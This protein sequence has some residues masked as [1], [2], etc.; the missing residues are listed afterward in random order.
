[1]NHHREKE[2]P[3]AHVIAVQLLGPSLQS[4]SKQVAHLERL[5]TVNGR[6]LMATL[7]DDTASATAMV[8]I[9]GRRYWRLFVAGKSR[10]AHFFDQCG[11]T[12]LAT[13]LRR[14]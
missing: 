7:I 2:A 8:K 6:T 11:L 9:L 1:M 3:Q 4:Q 10:R 14:I 12:P 5:R 13:T